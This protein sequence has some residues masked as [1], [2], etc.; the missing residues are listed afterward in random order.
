MEQLELACASDAVFSGMAAAAVSIVAALYSCADCAAVCIPDCS[1]TALFLAVVAVAI[2]AAGV[3]D[4]SSLAGDTEDAA[5]AVVFV[6]N[7]HYT[8][9]TLGWES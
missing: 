7:C 6:T 5:A 4:Q 1:E 8:A 9:V 2:F 3:G